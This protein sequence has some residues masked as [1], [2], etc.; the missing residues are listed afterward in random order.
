MDA[1]A[2]ALWPKATPP[3]N[4]AALSYDKLIARAS[5]VGVERM[6]EQY[7]RANV[8]GS[9][10]Y[11]LSVAGSR[12][13]R[14]KSDGSGFTNLFL[15]G[16]W[17]ENGFLDAGCIEACTLSGLQCARAISGG[18]HTLAWEREAEE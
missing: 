13:Y 9:E 15:A 4:P 5:A 6:D 18:D 2:G 11:V 12:H 16:D 14:L 17:T 7:F 10:R 1:H 8:E 3:G